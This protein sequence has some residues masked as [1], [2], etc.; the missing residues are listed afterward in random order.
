[1]KKLLNIVSLSIFAILTG[2]TTNTPAVD[3]NQ[4]TT[5]K[6]VKKEMSEKTILKDK[7]KV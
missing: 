1:M 3:E 6:E 4:S 7:K 5:T 2:C